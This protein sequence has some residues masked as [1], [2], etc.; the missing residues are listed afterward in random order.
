MDLKKLFGTATKFVNDYSIAYSAKRPTPRFTGQFLF[1]SRDETKDAKYLMLHEPKTKNLDWIS[2]TFPKV[3]YL[4]I[5][6]TRDNYLSK[7]ENVDGVHNLSNLKYLQILDVYVEDVKVDMESIKF[8]ELTSNQRDRM[9]NV[10]FTSSSEEIDYYRISG[11]SKDYE[12]N[13]SDNKS[14]NITI[15]NMSFLNLLK[16]GDIYLNNVMDENFNFVR[17]VND[18]EDFIKNFA[19]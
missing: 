13:S 11:L 8:F 17:Y 1:P 7:L 12:E 3:E 15:T 19:K 18:L 5:F 14:D 10:I 6:K 4:S 16:K 2:D 9:I